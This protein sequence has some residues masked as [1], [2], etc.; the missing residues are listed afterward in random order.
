MGHKFDT[1][2]QEKVSKGSD[3]IKGDIS[4]AFR[5]LLVYFRK[6]PLFGVGLLLATMLLGSGTTY[7]LLEGQKLLSDVT[8]SLVAKESVAL[9]SLF[10]GVTLMLALYLIS[11]LVNSVLENILDIRAR[12]F[13]TQRFVDKWFDNKRFLRS[14]DKVD[15]PEQRIQEEVPLFVKN[16]LGIL[17]SFFVSFT[18]IVLYSGTL[19]EK[20]GVISLVLFGHEFHIKGYLLVLTIAFA[21]IWTVVTHL[22]GRGLTFV[23]MNRQRLE[24]AFRQKVSTVRQFGEE[25]AL[26]GGA[27]YEKQVVDDGYR[28]IR[29]NW[30]AY[31]VVSVKVSF[32]AL[33][34]TAVF[35]IMPTLLL[36]PAILS[37]E[38]SIGDIQLVGI[39]MQTIYLSLGVVVNSYRSLAILRSSTARLRTFDELLDESLGSEIKLVAESG[40]R[41]FT[42]K[43]VLKGLGGKREL[44]VG[45]IS[46]RSG[47]RILLKGPSG[48]GKSTLLK[49]LAGLWGTGQ[50]TI[51]KPLDKTVSFVPQNSYMPRASLADVLRYPVNS[52][53]FSEVELKNLL[54]DL[55]LAHIQDDL[56][57]VKDW[58]HILSK[59]EQ[60]RVAIARV[61]LQ[62]PDFVFLDESTSGID[63]DFERHVYTLL[64]ERLPIGA[65][66]VS[67]S[68]RSETSK[69]HSSEIVLGPQSNL[70]YL[71]TKKDSTT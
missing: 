33:M 16:M 42:D 63:A 66:L 30:S 2:D 14:S 71:E 46:I 67:I 61:L 40:H 11:I 51:T 9:P 56:H 65:A 21:L 57:S 35:M 12:T 69:Y 28:A 18:P 62:K 54:S 10:A 41:I 25:I 5:L 3:D 52:S 59:G 7:V 45:N 24:A 34:P 68:H 50:G 64:N 48:I 15:H 27:Q 60:Q 19:W 29:R 6:D 36:A 8:N 20:S 55:G 70:A 22:L 17:P 37:G 47:D 44:A 32:C 58:A 23:E 53:D 39:A 49:A 13:I 26:L 1:S 4:Y 31:I 38:R 43:L